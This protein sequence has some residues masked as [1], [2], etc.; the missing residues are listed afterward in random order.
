[1]V[2]GL[3]ASELTHALEKQ[4]GE[5]YLFLKPLADVFTTGNELLN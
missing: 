5:G 2:K 3:K 4:N 1:M